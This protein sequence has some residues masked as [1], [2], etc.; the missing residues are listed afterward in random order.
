MTDL[1]VLSLE[2]WDGVW[3]RNQHLVSR[4]LAADPALRVLFVEPPA[5]PLH[6]LR[7]RSVARRGL[8]L[9]QAGERLWLF[10]P[11][12]WLPRR[13]DP[14]ADRRLSS[15]VMRAAEQ[16]DMTRPVLWLNDPLSSDLLRRTGWRALYDITDD[17][18]LADRSPREHDR[19]V[20]SESYLLTH[21]RHVVVC[22]PRLLE[23]KT[24]DRITLIPNAVDVDAYR[25]ELP[26]RPI[27][28]RD[29]SRC[30]WARCTAT[31]WTSTCP[32]PWRGGWPAAGR[33]SS[34]DRTRSPPTTR[35]DSRRQAR[36]F[37]G[38]A[39]MPRIPAYLKNADVLVVPHVVTDF[40]DSLDP[41]KVYEYLAA[42]RPVVSTA[43]AGFRELALP[44]VVIVSSDKVLGRTLE[45]LS[46]APV[47]GALDVPSWDARAAAMRVVLDEVRLP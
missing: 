20:E 13:L 15:A 23:T 43:V 37:S 47:V 22:S 38:L 21:C 34:S 4:L 26:G 42:G 41:I 1:V 36:A 32:R 31:A 2:A 8:G 18:L 45:F 27:C 40:T 7:R 39:S 35:H 29:R 10:Q 14:R 30:T 24:A 46:A 6:A 44:H 11:T 28:P 16:M 5:D 3:R 9:R 25:G 12:K 33:S 17:W 19:L